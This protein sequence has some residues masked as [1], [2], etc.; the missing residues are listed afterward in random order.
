MITLDFLKEILSTYASLNRPPANVYFEF[1]IVEFDR[2]INPQ[3]FMRSHFALKDNKELAVT[4]ISESEFK[5]IIYKWFFEY[6]TL[7]NSKLDTSENLKS[8]DNFY[9]QIKLMTQEKKDLPVS[10]C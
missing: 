8:V 9:S 2:S 10:K 7:K 5:Q 3:D 6:G 1:D 4:E